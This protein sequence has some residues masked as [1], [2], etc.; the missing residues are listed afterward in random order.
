[1]TR[2][3]ELKE[4]IELERR[5]EPFLLFRSAEGEQRL[6]VLAPSASPITIGR[7]AEADV[8]LGWDSEVSRLHS[9]IE[10]VG[11]DWVLVDDGL[12]R[13]GSFVN[14]ARMLGRHRLEDGDRLCF[15]E[16]VVLYRNPAGGGSYS[17]SPLP[18]SALTVPLTPTQYKVLVALC[19]PVNESAFATPATNREIAEEIMLSVD[20][21]KAQLRVLFDRFGLEA[22]PQNQKRA[23]LAASALVGG[24]LSPR[25][26]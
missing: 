18:P 3:A 24:L 7:R 26:F 9:T 21:V 17:T 12:S 15:G 19:R 4:Q 23:R 5:G 1:M 14:G 10:R 22:L 2:A 16:T 25:D 8:S 11:G 20:A 6:F 13:N